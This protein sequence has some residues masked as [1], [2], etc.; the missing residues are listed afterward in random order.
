MN[1][2]LTRREFFQK[3]LAASAAVALTKTG[4]GSFG[5]AQAASSTPV[6]AKISGD[7]VPENLALAVKRLLAP[8]GGM[9]A[10]VKKGNRVLL[11][12][13][14][15]FPNPPAQRATTSP[16]L[17]A[18]VAREVLACGASSV[19]VMDNPVRRPEAC[20]K[21]CG[22]V[23]ALKDLGI[24]VIL[25]IS[26]KFYTPVEIAKG[27]ALRRTKV[28]K[29]A[30]AVDVHI[31]LP[32]AKS[33]ATTGFSGAL[34]GMMGLIYDRGVFH[35]TLEIN[36]AI[37]D[38][39][40]VLKPHLT[41]L[42]GLKVMATDGPSGPGE[43]VTCNTLVAGLNALAVDAVGVSLAPLYGKEIKPRQIRH[44]LLAEEQG[45]G[46]I[47]LPPEQLITLTL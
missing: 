24:S 34:K 19:L 46:K 43:L 30:L 18:A 17:V 42:D 6:L 16:E 21:V 7:G 41:I 29:E 1:H 35:S 37:A 5:I 47:D 10:F 14:I 12:P 9:A 27:K 33:H 20:L 13:N 23:E 36:Q 4:G 40:T 44:L 31:A 15:A 25:P 3:S 11:K 8:L 32:I 22:F 28:L 2:K 26:E 45:V 38:L 39:C